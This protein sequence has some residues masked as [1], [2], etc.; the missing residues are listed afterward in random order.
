MFVLDSVEVKFKHFSFI[1]FQPSRLRGSEENS[2]S[3]LSVAYQVRHQKAR[4]TPEWAQRGFSGFKLSHTI[5]Y[6]I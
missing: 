3:V 2:I 5:L 4:I 6:N 1:H